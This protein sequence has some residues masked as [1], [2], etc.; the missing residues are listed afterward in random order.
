M[1]LRVSLYLITSLIIYYLFL[2][3]GLQSGFAVL[4]PSICTLADEPILKISVSLNYLIP[5][6]RLPDGI[7]IN[8]TNIVSNF[9]P[10]GKKAT[11]IF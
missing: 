11:T 5:N 8:A 1:I 3:L 6:T 9:V 4:N 2:N 10:E 7:R